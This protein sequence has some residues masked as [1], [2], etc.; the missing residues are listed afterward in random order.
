[1]KMHVA[2]NERGFQKL[3][4]TKQRGGKWEQRKPLSVHTY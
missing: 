2:I 1:M 3:T 4:T